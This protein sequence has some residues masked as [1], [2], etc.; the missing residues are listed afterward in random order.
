V[1]KF[2]T[3]D[4][5]WSGVPTRALLDLS[6][7]DPVAT[8]VMVWGEYGYS[9]NMRLSDFA[10]AQALF[11]THH[12]GEPLTPDHGYPVR[13]VVPHLYAWKGPKWAR[14]VEYLTSDRRGF[15]EER[16][17]HNRADPWAEQR[18]S[19]QEAPDDGPQ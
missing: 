9:A 3:L 5:V 1:T 18:F 6:P 17:Y 7:P 10:D 19:Y 14:G 13:L 16:G 2:T 11:A 4:N 15:W 12:N 8:N